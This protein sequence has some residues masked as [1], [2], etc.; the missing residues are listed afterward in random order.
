MLRIIAIGRGNWLFAGHDD[1]AQNIAILQS[2]I[3]S[4]EMHGVN[5]EA[6]LADVLIRVQDHPNSQ[7]ADLLPH[8]WKELFAPAIPNSTFEII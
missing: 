8:R 2:F 4:C 6:Y 1:A 7:I 5:P 3:S